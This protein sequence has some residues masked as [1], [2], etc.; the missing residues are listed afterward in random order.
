MVA[1]NPIFKKNYE[2]YLKQCETADFALLSPVLDIEV[3]EARRTARIPFF[4]TTYTVSP[5]GVVDCNGNRADYDT[6]IILLKYLL[7]CPKQVPLEK[8]WV[9]FRDLKSS[10]YTQHASLAD[11]AV[12]SIA[13]YY[14]G[15]RSRLTSA[16]KA[17]NG[18]QPNTDYP[19][20]VSAQFVVLPRIPVLFLYNDADEHAPA[21]A[22]MLFERRAEHYLDPECLAMIGSSLFRHLK[23]TEA[24]QV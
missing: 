8:D 4:Q 6:C 7:M 21:R 11:Y 15:N 19:Y 23:R 18:K 13:K 20:D 3:D 24:G 14:A 22:F 5:S 12:Q 10:G 2:D 17:L 9:N 1:S 16:I